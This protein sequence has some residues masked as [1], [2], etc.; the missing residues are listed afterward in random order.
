[1]IITRLYLP[2]CLGVIISRAWKQKD[3][4]PLVVA[5][6]AFILDLV[7]VINE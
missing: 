4:L 5:V 2:I 6:I 3:I 7:I 1:M